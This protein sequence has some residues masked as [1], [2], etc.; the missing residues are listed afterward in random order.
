MT[1][2]ALL[3][4]VAGSVALLS[5]TAVHAQAQPEQKQVKVYWTDLNLNQP[6]DAQELLHRIA[7]AA[8]VV[9]G[10]APTI[11]DFTGQA[12]FDTCRHATAEAAVK[13][14]NSPMVTAAYEGRAPMKLAEADTH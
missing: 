2:T 1:R 13:S 7:N 6:G 5:Q 12:G 11:G 14:I 10:P 3:S 8:R 9:C 4:L